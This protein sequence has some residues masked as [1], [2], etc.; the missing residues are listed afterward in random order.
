MMTMQANTIGSNDKE[1]NAGYM[2]QLLT[3]RYDDVHN[4]QVSLPAAASKNDFGIRRLDEGWFEHPF[5]N[6]QF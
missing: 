6:L 3:Q 4:K 2:Y 1:Q 5:K